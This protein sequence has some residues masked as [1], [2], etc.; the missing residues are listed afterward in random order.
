VAGTPKTVSLALQGGGAH[1]AFS[2]GVIDALLE[3]GRIQPGAITATSAGAMNAVVYAEGLRTHGKDGARAALEG[4]WRKVSNAGGPFRPLPA[5]S[6]FGGSG[7]TRGP[8]FSLLDAWTRVT[9]PYNLNPFDYNPL[10]DILTDCVDFDALKSCQGLDI[11][12]CATSVKTGKARIF[13]KS[14]LTREAVL[15]SACLPYLFQAVQIDGEP[16]WD[17][18]FSGNPALWPLYYSDTPRDIL[19]VQL[20]PLERDETPKTA[21]D[22]LNRV[23]EITFNAA[24]LAE[25]RALAF[26]KDLIAE[27]RLVDAENSRLR[28]MLVH[29]IR[30]DETIRGL[31]ADSKF[32]TGW[33][34]LTHLRDAGRDA[35]FAWLE[36]CADTVGAHSTIDLRGDFLGD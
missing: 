22:I 8:I 14:D 2:W 1:G 28:D 31:P 9:S 19:I 7:D 12:V 29:A 5:A 11:F 3:D 17:G 30:A 27:H 25:L 32:D 24:L 16:Y 18:G 23:N 15:A 10:R 20:N 13:D 26:V 36:R 6:L 33:N 35:A 34:A 21:S 4:F